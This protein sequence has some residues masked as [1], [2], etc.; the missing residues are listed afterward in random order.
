M[1]INLRT[2]TSVICESRS[3]RNFILCI[4][5]R[6]RMRGRCRIYINDEKVGQGAGHFVAAYM[7]LVTYMS[8]PDRT[9]PV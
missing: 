4:L 2:L 3:A 8:I 1:D 7:Q 6:A 9:L 5:S